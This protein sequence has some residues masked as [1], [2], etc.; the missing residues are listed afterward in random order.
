MSTTTAGIARDI[1]HLVRPQGGEPM[2][3]VPHSNYQLILVSP[4]SASGKIA[5]R[6]HAKAL[7]LHLAQGG[8]IFIEPLEGSPRIVQGRVIGT[9]P[10][11]NRILADVIVPMW[12]DVPKGQAA[13][14]FRHGDL[15]N[16][17]LESGARF[18][19]A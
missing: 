5:G 1:A 4:A 14:A 18:E 9:D 8:G 10:V 2:F 11:T 3:A 6:V 12:I 17:Y 15:V 16:G 7:K 19:P 13:S